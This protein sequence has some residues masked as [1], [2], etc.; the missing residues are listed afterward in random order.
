M[1]D[2]SD[3]S[4]LRQQFY[5]FTHRVLVQDAHD[6]PSLWGIITSDR[7]YGYLQTRWH[8]AGEGLEQ[9][10]MTGM[11]WVEPIQVMGLEICLLRM[12]E[13]RAPTEPYFSAFVRSDGTAGLRYFVLERSSAGG[14]FWSEWQRGMRIRGPDVAEWPP[15]RASRQA[16]PYPYAAA[17]VDAI[18]QEA[19][20]VTPPVN[21]T[22][23]AAAIAITIAVIIA[24]AIVLR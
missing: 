23:N 18:V 6:E 16:L 5:N 15:S 10:P 21:R 9:H 20:I 24:L 19:G 11:L 22:R 1:T 4:Q 17:F 12:P 8:D 3:P 14:A 13:P 2:A 7:A